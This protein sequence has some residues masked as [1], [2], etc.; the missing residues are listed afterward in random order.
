MI[1]KIIF[2]RIIFCLGSNVGNRQ[3]F[4]GQAVKFLQEKLE[5]IN[6]K[7]SSIFKNKALLLPNAPLEWDIDFYNLAFSADINLEK[8]SPLEIL[9][10]TKKI[11]IDLGKINRG[12]WAPREIDIDI[13]AIDDLKINFGETLQI[14]HPQLFN[15]D[16][17]YKTIAEIEPEILQK[18][19]CK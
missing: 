8:F 13:A 9:K 18:L 5:L 19:K 11:E 10:I 3:F 16:F 2:C 14:P 12:K 6:L 1:K 15:R 4:L 17:F 7:Q